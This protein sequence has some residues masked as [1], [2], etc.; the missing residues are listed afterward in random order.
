MVVSDLCRV[1]IL[2]GTAC[3]RLFQFPTYQNCFYVASFLLRVSFLPVLRRL[4]FLFCSSAC[5]RLSPDS[6]S[7]QN[8]CSSHLL[9]CPWSAASSLPSF[10]QRSESGKTN[11]SPGKSESYKQV[12]FAT[13]SPEGETGLGGFLTTAR[14]QDGDRGQPKASRFLTILSGLFC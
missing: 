8:P 3:V 12:S 1:R 14:G 6:A 4:E 2:P 13:L 9:P 7:L 11:E 5:D 10:Q